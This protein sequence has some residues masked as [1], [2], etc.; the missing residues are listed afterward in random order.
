MKKLSGEED[1][2]H[3]SSSEEN[4]DF[5]NVVDLVTPSVTKQAL[6]HGTSD[7]ELSIQELRRKQRQERRDYLMQRRE[8]PSP[9]KRNSSGSVSGSDNR[10]RRSSDEASDSSYS[11]PASPMIF[12]S[13]SN[14]CRGNNLTKEANKPRARS[15]N[16]C[17]YAFGSSTKRFADDKN[18]PK[19]KLLPSPFNKSPSDGVQRAFESIGSPLSRTYSDPKSYGRQNSREKQEIAKAWLK[20]KED[21][22]A[23]MQ[24][25][26]NASGYYKNLT[27]MMTTKMESLNAAPDQVGSATHELF[28]HPQSSFNLKYFVCDAYLCASIFN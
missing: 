1:S 3:F 7:D 19:N 18:F 27:D 8:S 21:I 12:R 15:S 17:A 9:V 25:K 26:P 5:H 22:E 23:A 14:K 11:P 2:G 13:S 6:I 10:G 4:T 16:S 24:K 28:F 20:F